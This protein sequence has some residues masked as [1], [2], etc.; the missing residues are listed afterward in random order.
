MTVWLLLI[1]APVADRS[2]R[3]ADG[4]PAACAAYWLKSDSGG[5]RADAPSVTLAQHMQAAGQ[6]LFITKNQAFGIKLEGYE[7]KKCQF[8][9][10]PLQR[11]R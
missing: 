1:K 10:Q 5:Y 4:F 8:F 7:T 9:R 2:H 6:S 11:Q 3:A